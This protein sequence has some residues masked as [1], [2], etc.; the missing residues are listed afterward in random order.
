MKLQFTLL[1]FCITA[2]SQ[3][4]DRFRIQY[5][6]ETE[7]ITYLQLDKTDK[8]KDTLDKPKIKRNSLVEL[9]LKNVNPFAVDVQTDVKEEELH[10]SGQGGFNFS[11]L[12]GGIN[13]FS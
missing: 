5:D 9:Q 1:I 7:K 2:L 12:L 4:Q 3:A 13:S 10:Q 8:V 6:Y 11:S